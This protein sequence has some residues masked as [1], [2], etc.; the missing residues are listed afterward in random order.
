MQWPERS[1][2]FE[3]SMEWEANSALS[4]GLK[5]TI[6]ILTVMVVLGL[7]TLPGL[8][9]AVQRLRSTPKTEEQARRE[10]MQEPISTPTDVQVQARMF[11]VSAAS[12][13]SVEPTAIQLPLSANPIERSKQLLNALITRA[14]APEKR[15]LP[16]EASLLAFY[17]QPDGTA[18]ADFSDEIASG[19]PS[20]IL[21]EQL[22]VQSIVQTLGANMTGIRQLKIL[23]HGQEAETLAGHLDLYGLFAVPSPVPAA[24]PTPAVPAA[25]AKAMPSPKVPV[26]SGGGQTKPTNPVQ[27]PPAAGKKVPQ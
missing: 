22:A 23:V 1:Q 17:I 27:T 6:V 5:T 19:L 26:G 2:R 21:S 15:T 12:P 14:P 4:K 20:G 13:Y 16:A 25:P 9:Q 11:W 18:I 10:V 3:R 7:V 8:R 24:G